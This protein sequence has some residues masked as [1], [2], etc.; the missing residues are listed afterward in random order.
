MSAFRIFCVVFFGQH[1]AQQKLA[2]H[3]MVKLGGRAHNYHSW[4]MR[5]EGAKRSAVDST[6]RKRMVGML[7][8]FSERESGC[9]K[10][11]SAKPLKGIIL[12][13]FQDRHDDP[14][15]DRGD[16]ELDNYFHA[17]KSC[18]MLGDLLK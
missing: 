7:A 12:D 2:F 18:G 11:V 14:D 10:C 1:N 16:C 15:T 5:T 9:E 6:V 17:S 13:Q 3:S 8:V 4:W